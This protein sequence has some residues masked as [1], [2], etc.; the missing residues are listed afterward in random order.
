[1]RRDGGWVFISHSRQDIAI[2]RRIRNQLEGLGFEPLLF[3]LRSLSDDDE[4]EG[5]IKREIDAREWFIYVDSDHARNSRWVCSERA[6]VRELA[7]KKIFTINIDDDIDGQVRHIANQLQV[8]ISYSHADTA[9]VARISNV[10]VAHDLLVWTDQNLKPGDDWRK[11]TIDAL[12]ASIRNGFVLVV[13]SETSLRSAYVKREFDKAK[14]RG[15][16]LIPIYVDDVQLSEQLMLTLGDIQGVRIS[17]DPTDEELDRLVDSIMRCV[18]YYTSDFRDSMGFRGARSIR[19]PPLGS[20]DNMTFWDCT[21]LE[22]VFIPASVG[23]IADD[24]LDDFPDLTIHC[25]PGSYA[26][27]WCDE[28]GRAWTP[29]ED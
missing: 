14:D 28:H 27:R 13:I 10:L 29:Y 12:E 22:E 1:M 16:K 6:Y 5:L 23:Y 4:I 2:V 19:L 25:K 18:D 7:G 3:Y 9:L 15:A 8:F 11:E 26:A 17:S 24:A 20:I 21:V